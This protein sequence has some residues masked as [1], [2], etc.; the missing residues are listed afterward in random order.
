MRGVPLGQEPQK[1]NEYI[2]KEVMAILGFVSSKIIKLASEGK[3]KRTRTGFYCKESVDNYR[4]E[5]DERK[6]IP[7]AKWVR[8]GN[9]T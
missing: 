4:K 8:R 9:I 6:G 7:S 1:D 5:M 3:I 2:G